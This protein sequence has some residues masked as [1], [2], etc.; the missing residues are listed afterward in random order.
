MLASCCSSKCPGASI[1]SPDTTCLT[2]QI[3]TF[4]Y[5]HTCKLHADDSTLSS[6]SFQLAVQ[7]LCCA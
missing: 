1:L 5:P 7:L 6:A 3:Y 4:D 2:G